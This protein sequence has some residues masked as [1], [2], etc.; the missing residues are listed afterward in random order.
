MTRAL[1]GLLDELTPTHQF[2]ATIPPLVRYLV[3]THTADLLDVPPSGLVDEA[4]RLGGLAR[5]VYRFV[6]GDTDHTSLRYEL[7][8]GIVRPFGKE[9]LRGLFELERGGDRAPFDI[10]EHLATSWE[11][12]R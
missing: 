6:V 8:A 2:D 11:L 10:P 7:I 4:E 1:L 3:G 5:L 9:L 12:S